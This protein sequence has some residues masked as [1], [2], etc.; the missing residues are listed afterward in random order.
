ML[1][2]RHL[3]SLLTLQTNCRPSMTRALLSVGMANIGLNVFG[4]LG[5]IDDYVLV[6]SLENI[7]QTRSC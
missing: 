5:K 4:Q 6:D 7:D 3:V 1:C 2:D